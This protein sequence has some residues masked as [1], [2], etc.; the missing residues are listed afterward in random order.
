MVV[1]PSEAASLPTM[2]LQASEAFARHFVPCS[3][4]HYTR[5]RVGLIFFVNISCRNAAIHNLPANNAA[6]LSPNLKDLLE[7]SNKKGKKKPRLSNLEVACRYQNHQN[8]QTKNLR[9]SG[10]TFSL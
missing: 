7:L 6:F 1:R 4:G 2:P 3:A 5:W 10:R 8:K 9:G